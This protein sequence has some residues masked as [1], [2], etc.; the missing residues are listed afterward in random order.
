MTDEADRSDD[1]IAAA[2][3]EGLQRVRRAPTLPYAGACYFC[4]EEVSQP[5]R[6]CDSFCRDDFDAMQAAKKRHGGG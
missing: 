1:R 6:F 3:E 2:I 5:L 4:G